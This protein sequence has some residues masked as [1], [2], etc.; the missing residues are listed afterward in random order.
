LC[1]DEYN[2]TKEDKQKMFRRFLDKQFMKCLLPNFTSDVR[3]IER[4]LDLFESFKA[5]YI[6]LK[7]HKS[8]ENLSF[9]NAILIAIVSNNNGGPSQRFISKTIGG[10]RYFMGKVVMQRIHVD[11]TRENIWG[12]LLWKTRLDAMDEINRRLIV[13]FWEIT[14]TISPIQKDVKRQHT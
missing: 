1:G 13:Q 3:E 11:L 10:T 2:F 7:A 4:K 8:K 5:T 14:S 6:Q 12:G 9:K